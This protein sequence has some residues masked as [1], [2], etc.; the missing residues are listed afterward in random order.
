MIVDGLI[1]IGS[2]RNILEHINIEEGRKYKAVRGQR[3]GA[4]AEILLVADGGSL[5]EAL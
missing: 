4:G 1:E 2:V 5:I 3:D